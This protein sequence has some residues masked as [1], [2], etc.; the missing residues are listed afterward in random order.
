MEDSVSHSIK[1]TKVDDIF[2]VEKYIFEEKTEMA[3]DATAREKIISDT[4]IQYLYGNVKLTLE[5][6]PT[7]TL[8]NVS[9]KNEDINMSTQQ[10][11][12]KEDPISQSLVQENI[13]GEIE[14]N[15]ESIK[16]MRK[17]SPLITDINQKKN[18]QS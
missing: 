15:V 3:H 17:E 18:D 2:Q 12:G 11:F 4:D 16:E 5:E 6:Q 1:V 8:P 9:S 13:K 14:S 7:M 10:I